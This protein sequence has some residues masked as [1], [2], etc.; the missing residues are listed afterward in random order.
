MSDSELNSERSAKYK[1]L[2]SDTLVIYSRNVDTITTTMNKPRKPLSARRLRY[3]QSDR[4]HL[5]RIIRARLGLTQVA[6]GALMGCTRDSILS[7]EHSKRMYTLDELVELQRI[8][9]MTNDE[10]CNLLKEIA[11]W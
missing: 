2:Q 4:G 1:E 8:S 6:M 7:R 10:W 11:A 3:E 5:Y 9:G